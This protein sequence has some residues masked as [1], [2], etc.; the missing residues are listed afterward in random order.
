[1]N[2]QELLFDKE[3]KLKSHKDSINLL[4][5]LLLEM[6]SK[7]NLT[8]TSFYD[9]IISITEVV[10]N[11]MC[12]GNK[13]D[14]DKSVIFK[15]Q[16]SAT[17]IVIVVKDEGKGFDPDKLDDCTQPDNLLKSSGRGVYIYKELMDEVEI[18]SSEQGTTVIMKYFI[19]NN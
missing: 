3:V 14:A 4:E 8:D 11:A 9:I 16:A 13:Y 12:H 10:N 15:M 2:I 19:R 18:I 7:I 17:Q 5:P 1:M 6:R